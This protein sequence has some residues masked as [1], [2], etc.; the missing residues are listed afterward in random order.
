MKWLVIFLVSIIV[1]LTSNI[2]AQDVLKKQFAYAKNLYSNEDYYDAITELKRLLFFDT[3]CHYT[4][5]AYMLMG[6]SYK[7]GG[8]FSD[9]ILNYTDAELNA[10]TIQQIYQAK[11]EIIR[12]NILRR[13]TDRALQ[14]LGELEKDKRFAHKANEINYWR[15]WDF[16]F[17]DKWDDASKSFSKIDSCKQLKY[18][19]EKVHKDKYSEVFSNLISH[20]I[21]GTGQIYTGNYFSGF[22]SLGWNILWG[23]VTVNSFAANRIFDGLVELNLLWLRFYNGNIQNAQNFAKEKNLV[24]TNK[25]LNY[26]QFKYDGLKP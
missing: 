17:A 24:I 18:L 6:K 9:A 8:K 3:G 15:G 13:T 5:E 25:A 10:K 26:L 22:L 20:F 16:M 4:F 19:A 23:Y 14:L 2:C 1:F 12:T 7:M 11:I 21:P